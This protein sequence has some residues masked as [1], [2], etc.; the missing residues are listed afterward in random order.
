MSA[1]AVATLEASGAPDILIDYAR[2]V[3]D[4]TIGPNAK[5]QRRKAAAR[6]L[7]AHRDVAAWMDRPT[8]ARLVDLRRSGAWSFLTWCFLEGIVSPDLDLVLAKIPGDLY[9]EWGHR[10]PDDVERIAEVAGRFHWSDNWTRDVSRRGLAVMC[11]WTA[12][13]L[14]ELTD[15]DFDA[16]TTAVDTAPSARRD[17]R[18]HNHARAFS[19][20]QACY[21]LGVC[22]TTPRQNR[23]RAA[24]LAETLQA[25]PQPEI[26][27]VVLRYLEV[28]ASTLRPSTVLMRADSLIVFGEYLAASHPNVGTLEQLERT[29]IDGFLI[30]NHGRPWRGWLARDKPVAASVSKRAVVDLR[31]FFEDLAIWGWAERPPRPLVFASDIPRLDRPLPR[32]LS[33][34]ADRDLIAAVTALDD[35]FV[36]HGLTILRGTGMRLGELLDLELDC[37]WDTPTHGTW[38][39]VPVGKL[40]TE[41]TVPLDGATM[42]A[43][44]AWMAHRGR[45]RPLAHPRDGRPAEFLFRDRGR[46]LSA[47]KLRHGLDLAV[48]EAGLRGRGGSPLHVTPH[49]LRHTY[50]TTPTASTD[51]SGGARTRA[52]GNFRLT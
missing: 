23:P 10:Y 22:S 11:L 24:T 16:F 43:F 18:S 6:F 50:A 47:Y 26:R 20:H 13:T 14:D 39:K 37:L 31:A 48:A 45:Q 28:V 46:R 29:H 32:A 42:A 3:A 15:D 51:T 30:F 40:G 52:D 4:L 2:F 38:V 9:A 49:Q 8:Q 7:D 44:D 25:L 36:R 35:P 33:P 27:K 41:R 5:L 19:L 1:T 21:E 12:K 17:A 34:D